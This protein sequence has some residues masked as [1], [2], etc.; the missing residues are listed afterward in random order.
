VDE[1]DATANGPEAFGTFTLSRPN[2]G[3]P[4]GK[5]RVE[6]YAGDQLADTLKFTVAA[7]K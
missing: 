5:Y 3:W 7:A 4:L 6:L 2:K 1:T